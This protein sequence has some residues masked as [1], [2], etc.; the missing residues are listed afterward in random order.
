VLKTAHKDLILNQDMFMTDQVRDFGDTC[1]PDKV[2][3]IVDAAL[4]KLQAEKQWDRN[5]I[6]IEAQI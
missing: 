3:S 6:N 4:S 5:K 1:D 2:L